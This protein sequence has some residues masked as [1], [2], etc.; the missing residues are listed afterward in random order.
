[1]QNYDGPLDEHAALHALG[2]LTEGLGALNAPVRDLLCRLRREPGHSGRHGGAGR[3]N[4]SGLHG[5]R[6]MLRRARPGGTGRHGG[7]VVA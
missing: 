6:P 2:D 3:W 1:M 5:A 4:H 7:W